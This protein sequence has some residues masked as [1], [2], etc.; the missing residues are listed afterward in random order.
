MSGAGSF[1]NTGTA[2][3]GLGPTACQTTTASPMSGGA[4]RA[5]VVDGAGHAVDVLTA[6]V[7][8]GCHGVA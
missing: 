6:A 5:E 8:G 7:V 2:A 3:S 1:G 4:S